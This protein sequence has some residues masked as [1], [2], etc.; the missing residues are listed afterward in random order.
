MKSID[1]QIA[2]FKQTISKIREYKRNA[3]GM[4]EWLFS[5]NKAKRLVIKV[6]EDEEYQKQLRAT[7]LEVLTDE[8][9]Q[10]FTNPLEG[11]IYKTKQEDIFCIGILEML[12]KKKDNAIK[13]EDHTA[14]AEYPLMLKKYLEKNKRENC[15][16]SEVFEYWAGKYPYRDLV[17]Y[18]KEKSLAE[19]KRFID[20]NIKEI[21][22]IQI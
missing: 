14:I 18:I 6:N 22:S 12:K 20:K 7:I 4:I 16:A 10:Y 3:E 21:I 8:S 11:G 9:K 17:Q 13:W 5:E 19:S 1:E 15:T 2:G